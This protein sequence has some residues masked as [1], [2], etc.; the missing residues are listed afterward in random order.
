MSLHSP[1]TRPSADHGQHLATQVLLVSGALYLLHAIYA[2]LTQRHLFGDASWYLLQML[3]TGKPTAFYKHFLSEFY[4]SRLTAYWLTQ[5]PAV[6]AIKLG[7]SSVQLVS[8][9]FGA[10]YFGLRLLS[11]YICFRLLGQ[12]EKSW[13][14]FPLLGLFAGTIITEMFIVTEANVA[15]SFLWP[16]A[17]VLFR[18]KALTRSAQIGLTIA[19]LAAALTYEPWAF[20]APMLIVGVALRAYVGASRRAV[21]LAPTVSLAICAIINWGASLYPRDPS[22]KSGFLK[23]T[24]DVISHTFGVVSHWHIGAMA[25]AIGAI[26]ALLLM[27]IPSLE[28]SKAMHVV[29]I[30]IAIV[31]AIAP[32]LHF[33]LNGPAVDLSMAVGDRGFGGLAM[34][35]VLLASFIAMAL[36]RPATTAHSRSIAIVLFGLAIGQVTWQIMATR[37]WSAAAATVGEVVN[38]QTGAIP[39]NTIDAGLVRTHAPYP[40]SIMCSW[41]VS[42]YSVLRAN[43]RHVQAILT[44]HV[45]F[46]PFDP[47]DPTHLPGA[48]KQIFDYSSYAKAVEASLDVEPGRELSFGEDGNATLM[49]GSGFSH[50]EPGQTWTDGR[51][52]TLHVCLPDAIERTRGY[53]MTFTLIPHLDPRHPQLVAEARA[54]QG[55]ATT[56]QF[57]PGGTAWTERTLEVHRDDFGDSRCGTIEV[58][59]ATL[60]ASPAEAGENADNRHLGLAFT[61]ATVTELP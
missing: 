25:A 23:G 42:P 33:Y 6:I 43:G 12:R 52:A 19:I 21:P 35:V 31:L 14:T 54:G 38:T 53:R 10:T 11:L 55:T 57:E 58:T 3:I 39:C 59:F 56:W 4:Y 27:G 16:I 61:K 5:L 44:A 49:L 24:L 28:R 51:K 41:W 37:A 20:F 17:I 1:H 60:P 34:Q 30:A 46:E 40:T 36:W 29:V 32:P 47:L 2:V 26:A 48:D 50:S 7:V 8:W 13:I 22:N 9:I 45:G 15:V 18:E